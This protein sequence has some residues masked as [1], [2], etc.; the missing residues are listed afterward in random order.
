MESDF[1]VATTTGKMRGKVKSNKV[2]RGGTMLCH[3]TCV[4][5][6]SRRTDTL[7]A[8]KDVIIKN[9]GEKRVYATQ[10]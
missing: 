3:C 9:E 7:L 5:P 2:R 1:A 8:S 10:D 4:K 6:V